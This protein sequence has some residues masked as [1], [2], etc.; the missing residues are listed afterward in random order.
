MFDFLPKVDFSDEFFLS[1][2]API[3]YLGIFLIVV[4]FI[5]IV[6]KIKYSL[7]KKYGN[8]KPV[9][10]TKRVR[11]AITSTICG[12]L[13]K[14]KRIQKIIKKCFKEAIREDGDMDG[15][16]V[17]SLEEFKS[18][19]VTKVAEQSY[20]ILSL[21]RFGI[22]LNEKRTRVLVYALLDTMFDE[23]HTT[24]EDLFAEA[25]KEDEDEESNTEEA[26]EDA[27]PTNTNEDNIII[28]D[29]YSEEDII[30]PTED[31]TTT[32]T[33]VKDVPEQTV[34]E[35]NIEY[36]PGINPSDV[37]IENRTNI[38]IKTRDAK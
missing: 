8:S 4:L 10:F 31:E 14:N 6:I 26:S 7:K 29:G 36:A 27:Q 22:I 24:L 19:L 9:K 3:L 32:E 28:D 16:G 25:Y 21:T 33:M 34:N 2:W 37:K 18:F 38:R 17:V 35:D 12:W 20:S 5:C 23:H 13:A 1:T 30:V 11:N 15:D